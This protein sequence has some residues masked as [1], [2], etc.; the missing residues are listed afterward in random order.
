MYPITVYPS[1]VSMSIAS[2]YTCPAHETTVDTDP[3][4]LSGE[5]IFDLCRASLRGRFKYA[6]CGQCCKKNAARRVERALLVVAEGRHYSLLYYISHA[7]SRTGC[8]G[9]VRMQNSVV[10]AKDK[11]ALPDTVRVRSFDA[12][13]NPDCGK[14]GHHPK[15]STC[16]HAHYCSRDCQHKHYKAHRQLECFPADE[17]DYAL[18]PATPPPTTIRK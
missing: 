2:K 10:R 15:C 7:C 18:Y 8:Q 17:L 5:A 9:C 4:L 16:E 13:A 11:R 6:Y 1:V 14:L 3:L 12:C